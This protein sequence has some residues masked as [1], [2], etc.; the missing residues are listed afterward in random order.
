MKNEGEEINQRAHLYI[1]HKATESASENIHFKHIVR[2]EQ[3]M[4]QAIGKK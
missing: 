4:K 1:N 3:G 2:A